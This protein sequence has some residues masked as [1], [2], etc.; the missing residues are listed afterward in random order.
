VF[1]PRDAMPLGEALAAFMRNESAAEKAGGCAV[2][3]PSADE[4]QS[5]VQ[6][7]ELMVARGGIEPPTRGFSARLP[8][9]VR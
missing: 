1:D 3:V 5:E 4:R 7:I 6:V 8:G 9:G 2:V